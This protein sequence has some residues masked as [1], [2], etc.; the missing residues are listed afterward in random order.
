MRQQDAYDRSNAQL[1]GAFKY[2]ILRNEDA[3]MLVGLIDECIY[4]VLK[5]LDGTTDFIRRQYAV[6]AIVNWRVG[7]RRSPSRIRQSGR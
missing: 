6:L 7:L 5:T 1:Y 3:V 4:K 2:P